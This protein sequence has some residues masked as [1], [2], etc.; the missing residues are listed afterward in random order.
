[1]TV[2]GGMLSGLFRV[3]PRTLHYHE[4]AR[5]RTLAAQPSHI[6]TQVVRN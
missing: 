5:S 3:T 4:T 1:M 6:F 2:Q